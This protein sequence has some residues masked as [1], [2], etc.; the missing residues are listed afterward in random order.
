MAQNFLPCDRE[1]ELL[2]VCQ[3]RLVEDWHAERF[4][5]RDYEAHWEHGVFERG[6]KQMG[7]GPRPT[8]R[9]PVPTGS[10]T[11]ATQTPNG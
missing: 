5:N 7:S 11:R 6:R 2:R 1:Q 3:R 9:P 4:A 10:S 8:P